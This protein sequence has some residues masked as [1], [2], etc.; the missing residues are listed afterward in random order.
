MIRERRSSARR[1]AGRSRLPVLIAL[2][3][4][5]APVAPLH[6]QY[7]EPY[8]P[9]PDAQA[10]FVKLIEHYRALPALGVKSTL[11]IEL[12]QGDA[13]ASSQ[14][15]V[16]EFVASRPPAATGIRRPARGI[17]RVNEF[18]CF[19]APD[20]SRAATG[21]GGN[22]AAVH[23]RNDSEYFRGTYDGS[24]YWALL[25]AF[26][27]LPYPHLAL[28]WGEDGAEDVSMQICA[29]T[30]WIVP[31]AVSDAVDE[32]GRPLQR[33][34][35]ASPNGSLRLDVDLE[36]HLLAAALHEV[37]GGNTVAPGTT[38]RTRYRFEYET[39]DAPLADADIVFDPHDR[40]SVDFLA[41]LAPPPEPPAAPQGGAA[42]PGA[43]AGAA[44][45][46][47]TLATMDGN[48][49]DLADLRGHV[50][51]LDFWATWCGPCR[52]ALPELHKVAEWARDQQLPVTVITINTFEARDPAQNTPDARLASASAFWRQQGFTLPVAM[53]YT[54]E[55]A[56][57]YG[58]SGIPTTVV[59]RSDGIV[60]ATHSGFSPDYA[61]LLEDEINAAIE[62]VGG[63]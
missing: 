30:P 14:E 11:A 27:S 40:Q 29:E 55:T 25:D 39:F 48:A 44:A 20:P 58:V 36:T 17:V 46:E 41:S 43:M 6:A 19:F 45:P 31:T 47:F 5:L 61:D 13:Q 32:R 1:Q 53:D 52:M 26:R 9:N 8:D 59:I 34:T 42:G 37:T 21:G 62:A 7:V 35:L 56:A 51:V 3:A 60:H 49:V 57:A 38:K 2:V 33:I 23:Q 54:D 12:L 15:V 24:P 50:V 10:A 18:E 28:L 22:F 16:A 63:D 4:A